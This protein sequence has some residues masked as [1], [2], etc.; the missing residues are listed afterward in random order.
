LSEPPFPRY[1]VL[2]WSDTLFWYVSL[3]GLVFPAMGWSQYPFASDPS[4]GSSSA[5][6]L[7]DDL[8]VRKAQTLLYGSVQLTL[9]PK[10]LLA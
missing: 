5:L 4:F 1:S 6:V 3:A 10:R 7:T 9:P 2:F 8:S